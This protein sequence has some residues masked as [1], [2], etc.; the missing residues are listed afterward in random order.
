MNILQLLANLSLPISDFSDLPTEQLIRIEKQIQMQKRLNPELDNNLIN[1]LIEAFRKDATSLG[2]VYNH[3]YFRHIFL[4]EKYPLFPP[5]SEQQ[6]DEN[7]KIFL[8]EYFSAD[9]VQYFNEKFVE[10]NF[11]KIAL[12]LDH[13]DFLSEEFLLLIKE[14]MYSRIDYAVLN[15]REL[16]IGAES[17]VKYISQRVFYTIFNHL[18]SSETDSKIESLL[19]EIV[20]LY[21]KTH[22]SFC[23]RTIIAMADYKAIDEN[24]V[25]ILKNNKRLV[26]EKEK[27]K[28]SGISPF[29]VFIIIVM[30]VKILAFIGRCSK[31]INSDSTLFDVNDSI[32]YDSAEWNEAVASVDI[33]K[34]Y[35]TNGYL[36]KETYQSYKDSLKTGDNPYS[37]IFNDK[38]F[39]TSA[40]YSIFVQNQTKYDVVLLQYTLIRDAIIIPTNAFY[41]K[42][43]EASTILVPMTHYLS[44]Y[45]GKNPEKFTIKGDDFY[46]EK[47]DNLPQIRFAELAPNAKEHIYTFGA[48]KESLIIEQTDSLIRLHSAEMKIITDNNTQEIVKN[49]EFPL[50]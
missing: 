37:E 18:K 45:F 35:L 16:Q 21:N 20:D 4:G 47:I 41:I 38:L 49:I 44:F 46:K 32:K 28:S 19:N 1:R 14:K 33:F 24:M 10:N 23:I 50:K 11:E 6:V 7:V 2:F 40:L 9:L 8:Q 12:L 34:D 3:I 25:K 13:K 31:S 22:L 26:S 5:K 39:S 17:K 36:K 27:K 43:K 29:S 30:A 48:F 42:S 15:L